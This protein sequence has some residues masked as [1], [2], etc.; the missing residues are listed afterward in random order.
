M[1][2][3]GDLLLFSAFLSFH[4]NQFPFALSHIYFCSSTF[5]A[6]RR[7]KLR[8][9]GLIHWSIAMNVRL[10]LKTISLLRLRCQFVLFVLHF[11]I[12]VISVSVKKKKK[13]KVSLRLS[14]N[15]SSVA[16]RLA[17][18]NQFEWITFHRCGMPIAYVTVLCDALSIVDLHNL[19]II[20]L[21]PEN[22]IIYQFAFQSNAYRR[23]A[24][25]RVS[26]SLHFSSF[27]FVINVCDSFSCALRFDTQ[28]NEDNEEWRKKK[29]WNC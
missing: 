24:A 27:L 7:C 4:K 20:K 28:T 19:Q 21:K 22:N 1:K 10:I 12:V 8:S 23:P 5:C 11:A 17:S 14:G 9:F 13:K 6:G 15:V 26:F 18:N 2:Q 3:F 16:H 29:R 25:V